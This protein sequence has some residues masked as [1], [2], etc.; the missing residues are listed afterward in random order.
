MLALFAAGVLVFT[1]LGVVWL[2]FGDW[3]QRA[4]GLVA[5]LLFGVGA[6]VTAPRLFRPSLVLTPYGIEMQPSGLVLWEDIEDVAV[7]RL[8]RGARALGIRLH[9]SDRYMAS[10]IGPRTGW[11]ASLSRM[12]AIPYGGYQV[13][14]SPVQLDRPLKRFPAFLWQ[15]AQYWQGAR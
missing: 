14:I 11:R 13:L 6:V 9:R 15:Y 5:V 8:P 10:R 7:V 3:G 1:A 12:T 2:V 4:L